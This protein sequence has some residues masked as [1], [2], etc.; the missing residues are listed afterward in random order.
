RSCCGDVAGGARWVWPDAS[1]GPPNIPGDFRFPAC[2]GFAGGAPNVSQNGNWTTTGTAHFG[3]LSGARQRR[4]QSGRA[5]PGLAPEPRAKEVPFGA[6]QTAGR[7]KFGV[8]VMSDVFYAE[9]ATVR[10]VKGVLGQV[11]VSPV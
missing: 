6:S 7:A 11:G 8:E 2:Q 9:L 5:F 10:F 4:R 3:P 1:P